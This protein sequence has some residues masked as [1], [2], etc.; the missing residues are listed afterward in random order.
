LT[1]GTVA[2]TG[3]TGF[4]GR[5]CAAALAAAGWHVRMLVRRDP[6]HPSLAQTPAE[7]VQGDLADEAALVRLVRGA[8][9]VVHAAGII[10][11]RDE[12]A[13]L[14]VNRDATGRLAAIAAR[15]APGCRFVLLSSQAARHAALSPYAASKF[16][17]EEAART[18]LGD[19]EWVILR[20]GI[21]YGPG[22]EPTRSLLRLADLP[23]VPVPAAPEPR[24][25]MIHV[26][27]LAAAIVA[28]CAPG[29]SALLQELSDSASDGHGWRAIVGAARR[30]SA[31]R[32]VTV[33]DALVLAAGRAADAWSMLSGTPDVFGLGK[34]REIL[35]RD[36]RPDPMLRPSPLV[37][38]PGV[39]LVAG[40]R[41]LRR[42]KDLL[43]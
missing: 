16:A 7:M 26:T 31:P 15:E 2:L 4:I 39:E 30:K 42:Q 28:F 29:P 23:V 38:R 19:T 5:A 41:E 43:F 17:G 21:V 37:W 13:F 3:G 25:A 20:P 12:G 14:P 1:R 18:A 11:G 34:A 10:R 24:L 27:D 9:A 22:D 6:A 33:P 8:D 32:F 35:H 36:W 40:M